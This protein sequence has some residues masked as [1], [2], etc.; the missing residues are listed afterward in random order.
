MTNCL[1]PSSFLYFVRVIL[2]SETAVRS[3]MLTVIH[4]NTRFVIQTNIR[5]LASI[6]REFK[7]IDLATSSSHSG[8]FPT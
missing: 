5:N 4:I 7:K 2:F 3:S 6:V 1:V 8:P